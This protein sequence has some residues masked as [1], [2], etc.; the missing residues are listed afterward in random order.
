MWG[1]G[2]WDLESSG[3]VNNLFL[4]LSMFGDSNILWGIVRYLFIL[5]DVDLFVVCRFKWFL[6]INV[7]LVL[8]LVWCVDCLWFFF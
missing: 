5:E 7:F 6:F 2:G 4:F 3:W 8:F 1:G